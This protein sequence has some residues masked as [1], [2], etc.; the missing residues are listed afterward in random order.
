MGAI[1]KGNKPEVAPG[2][3]LDTARPMKVIKEVFL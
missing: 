3:L 2:P 1:D